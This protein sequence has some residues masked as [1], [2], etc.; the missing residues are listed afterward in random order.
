MSRVI[1]WILLLLFASTGIFWLAQHPGEFSI[2]WMGY[3]IEAPVGLVVAALVVCVIALLFVLMALRALLRSPARLLKLKEKSASEKGIDA[4]TDVLVALAGRDTDEANKALRRAQKFLPGK[5][6]NDVLEALISYRDE[7]M[8]ATQL[9]LQ[10][11]LK[12]KPTRQLATKSLIHLSRRDGKLDEA[13]AYAREALAHA[14]GDRDIILALY[15]AYLRAEQWSEAGTLVRTSR[16]F[17]RI[18]S[19]LSERLLGLLALMHTRTLGEEHP[20]LALREAKTAFHHQPGLTPAALAYAQQLA[21]AGKRKG[22]V[23]VIEKAWALAPHPAL[24]EMMEI[25]G[26]TEAG[27]A[28]KRLEKL[29]SLTPG[30]LESLLAEAR[31]AMLRQDYEAA[32]KWLQ[33][34]RSISEQPRILTLLAEVEGKSGNEAGRV[35]WLKEATLAGNDPSWHCQRCHTVQ[36]HWELHCHYCEA[37]DS[38][39]WG[40]P[41][42][43]YAPQQ[44]SLLPTGS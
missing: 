40:V 17:R 2:V 19:E 33:Q 31:A 41:T 11:M 37:F 21:R 44:A 23:K 18:P 12:H 30:H 22:M 15:D 1:G 5:P 26:G 14:P 34:A 7:N 43:S 27:E 28:A 6:V 10:R 35:E 32:R 13:V 25:Y 8:P 4:L 20:E 29:A 42:G 16:R 39:V 36:T 24:A 3:E 38:S 9:A